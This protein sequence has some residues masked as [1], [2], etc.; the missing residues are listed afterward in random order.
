MKVGIVGGA[1]F[2]GSALAL[3]LIVH[4]HSVIV[5][6]TFWF[7]DYLPKAVNKIKIDARNLTEEMLA[8]LDAL[9]FLAGLSND[10]MADFNPLLN[11]ELNGA[12]PAYLI[13]LARR[14]GVKTFIHGGSCSVYG[15]TDHKVT[16]DD[17]PLTTSPYGVSKLLGELAVMHYA[18][19]HLRVVAFRMGTVCGYSPRMRFDLVINAMVKDAM[20]KRRIVV[21]D[22]RAMRPIL[23]MHD[24]VRAYMLALT[25]PSIQGVINIMTSNA[26]VMEIATHVQETLRTELGIKTKIEDKKGADVRS[27]AV[28]ASRAR[29]F[30][31]IPERTLFQTVEDVVKHFDFTLQQA[32]EEDRF[33]NIRMFE[34]MSPKGSNDLYLMHPL[35]PTKSEVLKVSALSPAA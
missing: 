13:D 11:F 4:D 27:Y 6:D 14:A 26:T 9:I 29:G 1:G 10:P 8:G 15:R 24:A 22:A 33:Y 25:S 7:G 20:T 32:C 17:I 30:G 35:P 3:P 18:N 16:E 2:I 21:N 31:I 19:T 5:F 28:D 12:L 23:D 34:K